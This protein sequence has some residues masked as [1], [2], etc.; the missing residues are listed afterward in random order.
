MSFSRTI[1]AILSV[2]LLLAQALNA[3]QPTSTTRA[4][5]PQWVQRSDQ[6][7]QVLLKVIARFNP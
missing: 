7:A 3:Q 2:F 5:T 4:A 6:D 1:A